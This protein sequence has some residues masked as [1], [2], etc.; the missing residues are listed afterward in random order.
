MGYLILIDYKIELLYNKIGGVIMS[1]SYINGSEKWIKY[2]RIVKVLLDYFNLKEDD[3]KSHEDHGSIAWSINCCYKE[4][5]ENAN[6]N[7]WVFFTWLN[8]EVVLADYF[9]DDICRRSVKFMRLLPNSDIYCAIEKDQIMTYYYKDKNP[10]SFY[11]NIDDPSKVNVT[12]SDIEDSK[13]EK[14]LKQMLKEAKKQ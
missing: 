13:E 2:W 5:N 6:S 10:N 1:E 7:P 9:S 12:Y 11:T 14:M 8:N 3:S 4:E